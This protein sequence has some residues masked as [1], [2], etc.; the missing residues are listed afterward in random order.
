MAYKER[1]Y[2]AMNGGVW[3]LCDGMH[4][5]LK[6]GEWKLCYGEPTPE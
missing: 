4:P 3:A 2:R 1:L 6:C 5:A